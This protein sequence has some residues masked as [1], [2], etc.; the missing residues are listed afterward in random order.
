M[1]RHPFKKR[2]NR[3]VPCTPDSPVHTEH[4]LFTVRCL[5][6]VNR[7]LGSVAVDRWIRPLPRVS[8]AYRTIRCYSSRAPGCGPLYAD[9]P[10]S[11]RTVRCTPDKHCSLSGAPPVRWL[12]AHFMD[13][14]RFFL[15]LLLF[16]S[17]WLLCSFMSSFE[18]LHPQ[19]LSPILFSSYEL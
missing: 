3:I 6:H 1:K 10:V 19:C 16:L 9:W 4:A 17:L 11:H 18:A 8:G 2:Y 5:G 12:T 15:G 13:F 7:L 14:F